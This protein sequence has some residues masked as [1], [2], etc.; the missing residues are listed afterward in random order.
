MR[1]I[2]ALAGSDLQCKLR[3]FEHL[4]MEFDR[5]VRAFNESVRSKE[6]LAKEDNTNPTQL[7]SIEQ[8][9]SYSEQ[10]TVSDIAFVHFQRLADSVATTAPTIEERVV[11]LNALIVISFFYPQQTTRPM[12]FSQMLL[13]HLQRFLD[14]EVSNLPPARTLVYHVQLYICL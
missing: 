4:R 9:I 3:L 7:A 6:Q 10:Q 8:T 5:G 11:A 13:S 2:P 1:G 12:I 14:S